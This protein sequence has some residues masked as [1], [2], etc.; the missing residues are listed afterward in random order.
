MPYSSKNKNVVIKKYTHIF[1]FHTSLFSNLYSDSKNLNIKNAVSVNSNI[2]MSKI[3]NNNC[4]ENQMMISYVCLAHIYYIKDVFITWKEVKIGL[5]VLF[6]PLFLGK[7]LVINPMGIWTGMLVN[8]C[9][10][11][12]F[13]MLELSKLTIVCMLAREGPSIFQEHIELLTYQTTRKEIKYFNFWR[14]HLIES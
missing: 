12:D 10:V 2:K 11:M 4:W 7:W 14:K 3:M 9:I 6:A 8:L 5:D 13:K 1:L